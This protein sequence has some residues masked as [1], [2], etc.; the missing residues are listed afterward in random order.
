MLD[1]SNSLM[2][3]GYQAR[4][5]ISATKTSQN[6]GPRPTSSGP[7]SRRHKLI[8]SGRPGPLVEPLLEP[9]RDAVRHQPDDDKGREQQ[10]HQA[11][12]GTEQ[13]A[14]R[15]PHQRQKEAGAQ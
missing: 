8:N 13:K 6:S 2:V 7:L 11:E 4:K 15:R 10:R 3:R 12:K 14:H 9:S 5:P 1:A